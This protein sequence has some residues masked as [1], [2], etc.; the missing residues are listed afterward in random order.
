V[1]SRAFERI[2]PAARGTGRVIGD[3]VELSHGVLEACASRLA[4]ALASLQVSALG[5]L[6]DN[7]PDWIAADHAAQR[8]GIPLVP[9]P[10]FFTAEQMRA[11]L[12]RAG[13]DL[14]LTDRPDLAERL[15][16]ARPRAVAAG[17]LGAFAPLRETGRVPLP[18]GTGKITFTSGTTGQPK[19]VCLSG[20][21][22]WSVAG[23]LAQA[24]AGVGMARHLCVLPLPVLLENIAGAD[25][26]W[27]TGGDL[28]APPLASLGMAGA[29]GF[30]VLA[31][32]AAV[33]RW[34][35]H[36]LILLPQ[37]LKAWVAALDAGLAAPQ[38][39]RFVAVGGG[40]VATGTL[41]RARELGLP[42]YEGYGLSECASVVALNLPGADRPGTVGRPLPHV[43]LGLSDDGEILVE[44][45]RFL[46]YLGDGIPR[47]GPL[48]TGDLGSID[49]D[50][51]VGITG[52]RKNIYITSFG[53]NVSPE[54]PEAELAAEPAIAQ[55]VVFGE[56]EPQARAVLVP[57]AA[58]VDDAA[59][60]A[61]VRRANRR[62]PDYARVAR[63]VR[64]AAP[65]TPVNGLATPNGR[66]RRDAIQ[67]LH[68]AALAT[69]VPVPSEG[70]EA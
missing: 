1:T 68:A 51:F 11:A 55:A 42:V 20:A 70:A 66:P 22:T 35:P 39:L 43:R 59:L 40:K 57:A 15:G 46:G 12:T 18:A 16:Y 14:L 49:P 19:G 26:A 28:V 62:L 47:P 41:L 56:A 27:L 5:L 21:H 9:L 25:L 45:E 33:E 4:D 23:A 50:G 64:A 61:A 38:S 2:V 17:A 63:W 69:A 53:R 24:L 10:L 60:A 7:G 32:A 30:D 37:M 6:A 31:F 8:A 3:G 34:Q 67:S 44:G 54:W 52:R 48:A 29:A 36:S 58:G 13:V 65:F